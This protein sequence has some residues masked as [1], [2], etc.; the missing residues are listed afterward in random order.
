MNS[1][2]KND[3]RKA[4]G[5]LGEELAASALMNNGYQIIV[6]NWRCRTGEIDIVAEQDGKLIFIEVRTRKTS[7]RFGTAKESIDYR[8]QKQVRDTAQVYLHQHHQHA[9]A[10]R[11]DVITVELKYNLEL[12]HLEHMIAA[13]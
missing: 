9:R 2:P 10:I 4:T 13:F 12:M 11:F 1:G 8:K 5:R 7:G 6:R 3:H